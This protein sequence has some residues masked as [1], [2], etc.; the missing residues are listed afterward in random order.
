MPPEKYERYL[1][2]DAID[3]FTVDVFESGD[4][5]IF[6]NQSPTEEQVSLHRE[7]VNCLYEILKVQKGA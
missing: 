4:I 2:G 1:L 5:H 3:G 6:S 7:E